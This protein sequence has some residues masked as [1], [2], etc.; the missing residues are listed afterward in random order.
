MI[1]TGLYARP[2]SL[3]FLKGTSS[4][5]HQITE[6][7]LL[8]LIKNKA[9][10]P[11]L[12]IPQNKRNKDLLDYVLQYKWVMYILVFLIMLG[13]NFLFRGKGSNDKDSGKDFIQRNFEEEQKQNKRDKARKLMERVQNLAS[14]VDSMGLDGKL[15]GGMGNFGNLGADMEK[16]MKDVMESARNRTGRGGSGG[17]I[18]E[19]IGQEDDSSDEGGRYYSSAVENKLKRD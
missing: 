5:Q 18:D 6:L 11:Q 2:K 4:A 3:F 8:D 10:I 9:E 14:K 1:Y 16:K 19:M 12:I 7:K 13:V 17:R 15:G